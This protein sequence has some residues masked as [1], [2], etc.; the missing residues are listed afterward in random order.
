MADYDNRDDS[1]SVN[2]TLTIRFSGPTNKG[3][4]T[5][6]VV[7]TV[8]NGEQVLVGGTPITHGGIEYV[9]ALFNFSHVIGK[10]YYGEW[11]EDGS[12]FVITVQDTNFSQVRLD[13]VYE[14]DVNGSA[15]QVDGPTKVSLRGS[16]RQPKGNSPALDKSNSNVTASLT[17]SFGSNATFPRVVSIVGRETVRPPA[18]QTS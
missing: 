9:G 2:D 18:W 12:A 8:V 6:D 10:A 13:S 14:L 1:F 4:L 7:S 11:L 15:V 16:F 5:T 17:G 3:G